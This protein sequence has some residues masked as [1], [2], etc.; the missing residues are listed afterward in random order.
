M[1][2]T[3]GRPFKPGNTFGRG[4]PQ[5]SRN[6]A[7]IALQELLDGHGESITKKCALMA[8]QGDPAAMRLCME[9]LIAP[10]RDSPVRFKLPPVNTAAEVGQAIGTVLHEVAGGQLT[11][12]E[13]QMVSAIL[14]DQRKAIETADRDDRIRTEIHAPSNPIEIVMRLNAARDRM[15]QENELAAAAAMEENEITEP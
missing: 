15:N 13:G 5:G 8:L 12:G 11:P 4:R 10:R 14:E 7:T 1:K 2:K 6:K 3:P 9:R